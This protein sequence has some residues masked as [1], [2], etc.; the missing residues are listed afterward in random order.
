MA[1]N[2]RPTGSDGF[3][4]AGMPRTQGGLSSP[5]GPLSW[6]LAGRALALWF[7]LA[8]PDEVRRHIPPWFTIADDPVVRARFWELTHDTGSGDERVLA[9]PGR[10]TF[11]E[12]VVAFPVD[13]GNHTGDNSVHMYADDPVYTAFGRECMGWPIVHGT[14]NVS[15]LWPAG[16]LAPGS[17]VAGS[18]NRGGRTLMEASLTLTTQVPPETM[19]SQSPTWLTEKIIPDVAGGPPALH[20][21]VRTGPTR[22]RWGPVWEATGSLTFGTSPYDELDH[23]QP[24]EIV[25]AQYWSDIELW[26]GPGEVLEDLRLARP[27]Q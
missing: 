22:V 3:R 7:R 18:L 21:I 13:H 8:E 6:R 24:R 14:V 10:T 16:P 19:A 26:L 12:A 27:T 20:Q 4:G 11:R 25:S 17:R 15:P 2:P 5:Y 1:S 23:L 9:D